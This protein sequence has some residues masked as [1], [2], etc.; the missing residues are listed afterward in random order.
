MN[1]F[2][3]WLRAFLFTQLVEAPIVRRMLGCSWG[4]AL[5]AST[6]THPFVWFVFPRLGRALHL[7][8][9]GTSIAS[10]LF[11]WLVE[12]LYFALALKVTPRRALGVSLLANTA[13]VCLGL[14]SRRLFGVP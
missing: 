13:S 4:A 9:L 10:E 11:A 6:L 1:V 8:Y 7:G 12:A 5:L 3:M 14:V 2:S